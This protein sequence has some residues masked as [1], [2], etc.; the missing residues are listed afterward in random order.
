MQSGTSSDGFVVIGSTHRKI[1]EFQKEEI[2][3]HHG[4]NFLILECNVLQWFFWL[5]K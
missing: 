4:S 1:Q 3:G 5:K 2:V